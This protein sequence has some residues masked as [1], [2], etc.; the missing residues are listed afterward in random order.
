MS[1]EAVKL[2]RK[3]TKE[4]IIKAMGGACV[5]CGYNKCDDCLDLHHINPK[6]KDIS[7]GGIRAN[8]KNWSL[9]VK[10]LRKCVLVCAN[11][12]RE[13][14]NGVTNLPKTFARFNE[15]YKDYLSKQKLEYFNECPVCGTLKRK[16]QK[17]CSYSCSS[18]LPRLVDWNKVDLLSL[19]REGKTN[20]EIAKLL[21]VSESAV[22]KRE[23]KLLVGS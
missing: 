19:K 23:K 10:E 21:N 4:R 13:I 14:H 2:W 15:E 12:H 8:P 22:R 16:E 18:S 1:K 20:V 11:C 17:T 5:C 6:E 3:R 7:F 9:I